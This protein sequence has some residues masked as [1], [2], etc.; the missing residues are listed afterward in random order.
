MNEEYAPG[1]RQAAGQRRLQLLVGYDQH[2][3]SHQAVLVAAALAQVLGATLL[4][5]HV[6]D[7]ADYP[8]DPEAADWE[9]ASVDTLLAERR[10]AETLLAGTGIEWTYRNVRGDPTNALAQAAH[11]VDALFIVVGASGRGLAQRLLHS[12]VP[13]AL[14]RKQRKPVLVVPAQSP[15]QP[16]VS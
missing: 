10:Q 4:L 1:P 12:S 3:A 13:Q 8:V 6:I 11:E 7:L 16:S 14:L 5:L 2:P 15:R 9:T